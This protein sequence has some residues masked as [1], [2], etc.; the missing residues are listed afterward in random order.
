VPEDERAAMLAALDCVDAVTVFDE[1][2]P[3]QAIRAVRPDVL[4]KGQDYRLGTVV[5]REFVES[6][7]GKVELLPLVPDRST[8]SLVERIRTQSR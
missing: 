1:D 5:G 6:Y 4:V 3:D 8:S 7:G 2:T